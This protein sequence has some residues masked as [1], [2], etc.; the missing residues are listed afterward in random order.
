MKKIISK[1]GKENI[2]LPAKA[3]ITARTIDKI[4]VKV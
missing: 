2:N 3:I 1:K 4:I